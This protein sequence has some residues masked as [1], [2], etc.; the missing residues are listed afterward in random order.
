MRVVPIA[1]TLAVLVAS[2]ALVLVG[3]W[4]GA[5]TA[6]I[7]APQS[8][9]VAIHFLNEQRSANGIPTVSL[10]QAF[11]TAWCPEEND[12]HKDGGESVREAAV[13][14]WDWSRQSS[15]WDDGPLHQQAQYDPLYREAGYTYVAGS[16][17]LGL[18]S[19]STMPSR[20]RFYAFTGDLGPSA[21]PTG[22]LIPDEGPFSP[23]QVA[24]ITSGETGPVLILYALGLRSEE[25]THVPP[26]VAVAS[27][28]LTKA[29]GG[30]VHGVRL[31]DAAT[32]DRWDGHRFAGLLH[33]GTA[34]LIPPKLR[35]ATTYLVR[36]GWESSGGGLDDTQRF[37]F[38][39]TSRPT[40]EGFAIF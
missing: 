3:G 35:P 19:P 2:L 23:E 29:A 17:C 28:S 1:G 40:T 4:N 14:T 7:T 18:G 9:A 37:H 10:N 32:V 8:G 25:V 22:E 5:A 26:S 30:R 27:F 33:D 21:V 20:P 16:A 36:V 15:P 24:G 38:R 11:A 12:L 31:V 6:A 39:T 13:G 34:F